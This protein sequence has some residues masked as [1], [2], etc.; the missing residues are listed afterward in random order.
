MK[1]EVIVDLDAL[2]DITKYMVNKPYKEVVGLLDNLKASVR[3]I[4]DEKETEKKQDHTLKTAQER[5]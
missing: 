5:S 3:E 2:N 4:P 1:R